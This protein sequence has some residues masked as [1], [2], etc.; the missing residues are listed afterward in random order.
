VEVI[1]LA[2]EVGDR[3][4]Q[5]VESAAQMIETVGDI[6]S[7]AKQPSD[8]A[9]GTTGGLRWS[10]GLS[11]RRRSPGPRRRLIQG[12]TARRIAVRKSSAPS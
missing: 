12:W 3:V 8:P 6:V 5:L 10:H 1:D 4:R 11:H 2:A 7:I 9:G